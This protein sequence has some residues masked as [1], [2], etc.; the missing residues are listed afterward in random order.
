MVEIEGR[1]V[2]GRIERYWQS[3]ATGRKVKAKA[4]SSRAEGRV[5]IRGK[6]ET[7]RLIL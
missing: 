5:V 1:T 7:R 4:P 2:T 6:N 3:G